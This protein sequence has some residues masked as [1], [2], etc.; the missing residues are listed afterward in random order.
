MT[1]TITLYVIKYVLYKKCK[2]DCSEGPWEHLQWRLADRLA[3]SRSASLSASLHCDRRELFRRADR[4]ELANR[5]ALAGR[6]AAIAGDI[7]VRNRRATF[8][9]KFK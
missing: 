2:F 1:N 9:K 5:Q 4:R 7:S 3:D 8:F 6:L